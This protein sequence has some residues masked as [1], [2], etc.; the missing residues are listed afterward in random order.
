MASLCR[1]FGISRKS[2]YKIYEPYEQCGLDGLTD[3]VRRSFRYANQLPEQVECIRSTGCLDCAVRPSRTTRI[4]LANGLC[5]ACALDT[6]TTELF[7]A[8]CHCTCHWKRLQA[9]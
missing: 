9:A 8:M 7:E 3:R 5:P 2:G 1:E 6:P 4:V